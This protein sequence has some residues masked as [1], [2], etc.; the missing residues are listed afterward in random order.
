MSD[1]RDDAAGLSETG[2]HDL[3]RALNFTLA[4]IRKA[5]GKRNPSEL[6]RDQPIGMRRW[7]I[8]PMTSC[9]TAS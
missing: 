3:A 7:R 2:F 6:E 8:S 5:R 9:A 1:A 4:T